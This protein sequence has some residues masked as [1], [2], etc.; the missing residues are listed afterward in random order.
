MDTHKDKAFRIACKIL[1]NHGTAQDATQE[2]FVLAWQSMHTFERGRPFAPWFFKILA[3][4]ALKRLP[5]N[6]MQMKSLAV[7]DCP[8]PQDPAPG[9]E[10]T[11]AT[12]E[13]FK[14]VRNALA[15]LPAQQRT[16]IRLHYDVGLK[17]WEIADLLE[18]PEGTVKS[19]LYRARRQLSQILKGVLD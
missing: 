15:T 5:K 11:F 8:D 4:C 16:I 1:G 18:L 9:P 12:K 7:E 13:V 6:S 14:I 17:I 10:Q 2:A 19:E 3:R